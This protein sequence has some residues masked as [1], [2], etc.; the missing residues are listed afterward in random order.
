MPEMFPLFF[1]FFLVTLKIC[2]AMHEHITALQDTHLYNQ[3]DVQWI[4]QVWLS[5]CYL[6][7]RRIHARIR[8]HGK[9]TSGPYRFY[10]ILSIENSGA[11]DRQHGTLN[12]KQGKV[13]SGCYAK[14]SASNKVTDCDQLAALQS[15]E[16]SRP[17]SH[18]WATAAAPPACQRYCVTAWVKAFCVTRVFFFLQHSWSGWPETQQLSVQAGETLGTVTNEGFS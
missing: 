4:S 11:T 12:N 18:V 7:I 2:D 15:Q 9:Q 3:P 13:E 10:S 6:V 1:L 16:A 5:C 8:P 14:Q 17:S